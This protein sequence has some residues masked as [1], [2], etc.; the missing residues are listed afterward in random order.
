MTKKGVARRYFYYI[1]K[2]SAY[3]RLKWKKS[4]KW[5]FYRKLHSFNKGAYATVVFSIGLPVPPFIENK[6]EIS[7]PD[8]KLIWSRPY[9]NGCALTTYTVC[10]R[11]FQRQDKDDFWYSLNTT[12]VANALSPLP[13][14]C[15]IEYEFAV[16]AWNELGEGN[17]SQPWRT[18]SVTGF[19]AIPLWLFLL[20]TKCKCFLLRFTYT[21]TYIAWVC[22]FFVEGD[23]RQQ[24]NC[25]ELD[26]TAWCILD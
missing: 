8:F 10:Y 1:L 2:C 19:H 26:R 9:D 14:D 21:Y 5:P 3:Q 24:C 15:D 22:N 7:L 18:K 11:Q 25:M 23:I 13:L 17:L 6:K 12:A 16:S 20:F 4:K